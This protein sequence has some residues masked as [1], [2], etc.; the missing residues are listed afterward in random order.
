MTKHVTHN[1]EKKSTECKGR[2]GLG[3]WRGKGEGGGGG[4]GNCL[5]VA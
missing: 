3:K 4:G 1:F 2:E 5:L